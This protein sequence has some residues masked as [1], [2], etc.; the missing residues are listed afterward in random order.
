MPAQNYLNDEEIAD[1]LNYTR[2]SWTN[3]I[4]VA[5]TPAQVKVLRK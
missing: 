3:K 5:I 2:N 1:V 4:P